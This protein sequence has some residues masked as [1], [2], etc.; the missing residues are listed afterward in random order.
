MDW[1][2][3][4]VAAITAFGTLVGAVATLGR[5]RGDRRGLRAR[6][7]AD[8]ELAAALPPESTMRD[9]LLQYIDRRL[10]RLITSEAELRRDWSGAGLAAVIAVGAVIS[11]VFAINTTAW[12]WLLAVPAGLLAAV[13]LSESLP[14]ARRDDRGRRIRTNRPTVR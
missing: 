8:I 4:T 12:F 13:G 11:I 14:R 9:A 7:R 3:V 10:D 5:D 6:I 2:A 1:T